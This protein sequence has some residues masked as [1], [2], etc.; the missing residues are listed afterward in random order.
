MNTIFLTLG[1][2]LVLKLGHTSDDKQILEEVHEAVDSIGSEV[3]RFIR[4]FEDY[5]VQQSNPRKKFK[6]SKS[7]YGSEENK[8]CAYKHSSIESQLDDEGLEVNV[9]EKGRF[10]FV[11]K[12]GVEARQ[13]VKDAPNKG[14]D[15]CACSSE[16]N[17][18]E[19]K[20]NEKRRPSVHFERHSRSLTRRGARRK[21]GKGSDS[22]SE[23]RIP[24]KSRCRGYKFTDEDTKYDPK[25]D[26]EED[27]DNEISELTSNL[28][29]TTIDDESKGARRKF[30]SNSE[31]RYNRRVYGEPEDSSDEET[32]NFEKEEKNIL[33]NKFK[34]L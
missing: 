13:K 3:Q 28:S 29:N 2:L 31:E 32:R 17:S 34:S 20:S 16:K 19:P 8:E 25:H 33:Y 10:E 27:L 23:R 14:E 12:Q 6:R 22:S 26:E 30:R 9:N 15:D 4:I 21:R 1:A 18:N 11:P 24:T 7:D 5:I